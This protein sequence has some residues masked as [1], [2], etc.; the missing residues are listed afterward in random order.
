MQLNKLPDPSQPPP[1]PWGRFAKYVVVGLFAIGIARSCC[2]NNKSAP[3]ATNPIAAPKVI[4]APAA[5]AKR[6]LEGTC[7]AE[8]LARDFFKGKDSDRARW[9]GKYIVVTGP[10]E[11]SA[12][13]L[14]HYGWVA[15]LDAGKKWIVIAEFT[16]PEDVREVR[17][18]HRGQMA[19]I[20]GVCCVKNMD[21]I[22]LRE[23]RIQT[24]DSDSL[25]VPNYDDTAP[26]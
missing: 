5:P 6:A 22:E 25:R 14:S 7:T 3:S 23:P 18:W 16:K 19:S 10:V 8:T 13:L 12:G 15:R 4:P 2:D 26:K 11:G 9:E 21:S 20:E 1:F 24:F 17:S